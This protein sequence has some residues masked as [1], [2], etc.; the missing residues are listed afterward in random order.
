M[1]E[2]S[3]D[4]N[5]AL[6]DY[7]VVLGTSDFRSFK[8]RFFPLGLLIS[9]GQE[10]GGEIPEERVRPSGH[11]LGTAKGWEFP[12]AFFLNWA[13][14]FN[15]GPVLGTGFYLLTKSVDKTEK[16][17]SPLRHAKLSWRAAALCLAREILD[18]LTDISKFHF[19]LR[20]LD[21]P[22][23][24]KMSF[25]WPLTKVRHGSLG[26]PGIGSAFFGRQ[27]RTAWPFL[28]G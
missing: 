19:R 24:G 5:K 21:R 17:K 27:G 23:K 26:T 25:F 15:K 2:A 7:F 10:R 18:M 28:V 3:N 9:S 1:G 4:Y 12:K 13:E 8:P 16:K 22:F 6:R 11:L 20:C 14:F